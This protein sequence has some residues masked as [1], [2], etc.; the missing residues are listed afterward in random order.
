MGI[1]GSRANVGQLQY[2]L[3]LC[4]SKCVDVEPR[5]DDPTLSQ[6]VEGVRAKGP[7][8]GTKIYRQQTGSSLQEALYVAQSL[9]KQIKADQKR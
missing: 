2:L 6:V 9:A 1:M 8:L 5:V 7:V 3:R 4:A